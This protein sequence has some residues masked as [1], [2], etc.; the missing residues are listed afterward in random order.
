MRYNQVKTNIKDLI[1][2]LGISGRSC[3]EYI[4]SVHS[5]SSSYRSSNICSTKIIAYGEIIPFKYKVN[6]PKEKLELI[7]VLQLKFLF[8]HSPYNEIFNMTI[9][10]RITKI[11][12][13]LRLWFLLY[14]FNSA[15]KIFHFRV[16]ST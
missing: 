12:S 15:P 10:K 5:V 11:K 14:S 6:E 8:V 16:T 1:R 2:N 9:E 4:R 13:I 7:Q 3:F